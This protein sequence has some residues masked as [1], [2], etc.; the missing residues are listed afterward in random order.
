VDEIKQA[1]EEIEKL[2][3]ILVTR[4]KSFLNIDRPDIKQDN[5]SYL[6]ILVF[7]A[8]L[9]KRKRE[10]DDADATS[11]VIAD[12]MSNASSHF[13]DTTSSTVVLDRQSLPPS[14]H[15]AS[16]SDELVNALRNIRETAYGSRQQEEKLNAV[17]NLCL[18]HIFFVSA[19]RS[20]SVGKYLTFN[21]HAC[22]LSLESVV[23]PRVD[24]S[25]NRLAKRL[26]EAAMN[27]G[28]KYAGA[29]DE[30]ETITTKGVLELNRQSRTYASALIY[31]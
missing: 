1:G 8:L 12:D 6:D 27:L 22:L 2:Q 19:R 18:N 7:R 30:M 9:K 26:E 14:V 11:S 23:L 17:Q 10:H 21:Q 28:I 16:T 4:H 20:R 25:V 15:S 24:S 5:Y 31:A 13:T 3:K 29:V